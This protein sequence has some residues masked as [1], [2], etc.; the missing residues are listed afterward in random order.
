MA[1]DNTKRIFHLTTRGGMGIDAETGN[2]KENA[3]GGVYTAMLDAKDPKDDSVEVVWVGKEAAPEA[4]TINEWAQKNKDWARLTDQQKDALTNGEA[5][6]PV[7]TGLD[8]GLGVEVFAEP[9]GLKAFARNNTLDFLW[10]PGGHGFTNLFE[11]NKKNALNKVKQDVTNKEVLKQINK[12]FENSELSADEASVLMV[13][14]IAGVKGNVS[15]ALEDVKMFSDEESTR[16]MGDNAVISPKVKEAIIKNAQNGK[17]EGLKL[18]EKAS[19]KISKYVDFAKVNNRVSKIKEA[20]AFDIGFKNQ[21]FEAAHA[22]K[23]MKKRMDGKDNVMFYAQDYDN[24]LV[25]GAIRN[26]GFENPVATFRHIPVLNTQEMNSMKID[27]TSLLE[28]HGMKEYMLRHAASADVMGFQTQRD[29]DNVCACLKAIA[30]D[31]FKKDPNAPEGVYDFFG[32]KV[33]IKRYPIGINPERIHGLATKKCDGEEFSSVKEFAEGKKLCYIG[34]CRADY[35]KGLDESVDAAHSFLAKVKKYSA[36]EKGSEAYEALGKEGKKEFE[37]FGTKEARNT[38]FYIQVQPTRGGHKDFD[39]YSD[40]LKAQF[41]K[42]KKEF[43]G[44]VKTR[45]DGLPHAE[46]MG[47]MRLADI[48]ID[49][50]LKDGM[51]LV[52]KEFIAAQYGKEN[53]GM[54]I[55]ADGMGVAERAKELSKKMEK[56]LGVKNA[57]PVVDNPVAYK[58]ANPKNANKECSNA[59]VDAIADVIHRPAELNKAINEIIYKDMQKY[60]LKWWNSEQKKDLEMMAEVNA[61]DKSRAKKAFANGKADEYYAEKF[62]KSVDYSSLISFKGSDGKA[63]P[64]KA[65]PTAGQFKQ[66]CRTQMGYSMTSQGYNTTVKASQKAIMAKKLAEKQ[67]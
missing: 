16:I 65:P 11:E 64:R 44:S 41:A 55:V 50:S 14:Q 7:K 46:L 48:K 51:A 27:G 39:E 15:K 54:A 3:G 37:K 18:D 9:K 66:W 60:D 24:E 30:K 28:H 62:G 26:L 67:R 19:A 53:P 38:V 6:F 12:A 32:K 52:P 34:G 13:A 21:A 8:N 43:P 29:V 25:A 56:T 23:M 10:G 33:M 5:F 2:A 4:S 1:N 61:K 40:K 22:A 45:F 20:D 35:T 31:G 57:Y 58:S 49:T 17:F 59:I 36:I 42:M 63:T 47:V